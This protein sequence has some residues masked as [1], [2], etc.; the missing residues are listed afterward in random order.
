MLHQQF[1]KDIR[2]GSALLFFTAVLFLFSVQLVDAATLTISPL[3]SKASIGNIVS[4][5]VIVG[6]QGKSINNAEGVLQFP[7]D[8]LEVISIS[9]NSS[10]FSLWV[11]EPK[12]SNF[13]GKIT[14]NGGLPNPGYVGENGEAVSITFKAKKA[15]TASIVFADSAVRE[16][17]G[18]GTDI[19]TSR[20]SGSIEIKV[21]EKIDDVPVTVVA[22]T[23]AAPIV[24]SASHPDQNAWYNN[25]DIELNWTVPSDITAVSTSLSRNPAGM[26]TV[27]Y[28]PP[29]GNKK[30]PDNEDGVWYFN[31]RFMNKNG[32]GAI[33]HYKIQIDTVS[34]NSFKISFPHGDTSED[35]RPIINFNTTD[36]TSGVSYYEVKIGEGIFNRISTSEVL[37]NPYSPEPQD[38]GKYQ[39][40]VK[41]VDNARNETIQSSEF[42][43]TPLNT[44]IITDYPTE[45]GKDDLLRIRGTS[46]P[47]T[48]IEV[49]VEDSKG[50][51][52]SQIGHVVVDGSFGMVWA[53][54]LDTGTYTLTA[55]AIDKKEAKSNFTKPINFT[56]KHSLFSS[57]SSAVLGWLSLL[58]ILILLLGGIAL[59][60]I[61]FIHRSKKMKNSIRKEIRSAELAVHK[62][63]DILR[64][65]VQDQITTLEKARSKRPLTKEEEKVI[66]HLQANLTKAEAYIEKEISKIKQ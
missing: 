8:L 6:T 11:E 62:A 12:F 63:F 21:P 64:D 10:I 45:L 14:F 19:L 40:L 23:P 56:V 58:I 16:N 32:W 4:V 44:P 57:I 42:V 39:I 5:K 46:Y 29:I 2:K 66:K 48:N 49:V 24:T 7:S 26:P 43:I 9:K 52:T 37:S 1:K 38:P 53:K 31:I 61:F 22:G 55:R 18:F 36:T 25:N 60:I 3:S 59:L 27:I 33:A 54:D 20:Q 47:L 41:A 28:N 51:K 35:P 65:N 13:D 50:I 34:P 17:N 30:I 15:G